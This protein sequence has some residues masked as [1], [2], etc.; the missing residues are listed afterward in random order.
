MSSASE[1]KHDAYAAFRFPAYRWYFIGSLL[2]VIGTRIQVGAIG[3]D[4]YERT[5]DVFDIGLVGLVQAI[6]MLLIILP[7][8]HWADTMNRKK[9]VWMSLFGT[10]ITSFMLFFLS[11][12]KFELSWFFIV[13]TIDAFLLNA[14][15][16]ARQALMPMLVPESVLSNAMAWHS[17][18]F[19]TGSIIGLG[20]SGL[21]ITFSVPA[22]YFLSAM[23]TFLF[24]C[25]IIRLKVRDVKKAVKF[26]KGIFTDL[27]DGAKFIYQKR[28][29]FTVLAL[30]MFAVLLGG[31]VAL[32]PVFAK[33]ILQVSKIQYGY[34]QAAPAVGSV[35]M[36]VLIAHLPP[37]KHSG[38]NMLLAVAGFG[39]ST[40]VFGLSTN[41]WLSLAMMFLAGAF[42]NISVIV[43]HTL[44]Q[45]L[46]P[47]SMRGRVSAVNSVFI[48][49]S[50]ELGSFESGTLAHLTSP[51]FSVVFGGI[52]TICVVGITAIA[53]PSLRKFGSLTSA[54]KKP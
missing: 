31:A 46:T 15:K 22:A 16:P 53:S 11:Y 32:L 4:I 44:V 27:L 47:D 10:S 14:G 52:G 21:V 9:I 33:D 3:Y 5:G 8:G 36:G 51:V 2:T 40:I 45:L 41:Y 30:D 18:M 34:L 37:M 7:A 28:I 39:A 13:L 43:R 54:E 29:I 38:R 48:G 1:N 19:N 20:L 35:L 49:T 50:N 42:D 25:I 12:A 17:N 6:P 24:S 26:S 23:S